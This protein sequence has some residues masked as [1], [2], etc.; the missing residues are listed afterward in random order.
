MQGKAPTLYDVTSHWFHGNSIPKIGGR[1]FWPRPIVFPKNTLPYDEGYLFCFI[2]ISSL[3]LCLF[4][5]WKPGWEFWLLLVLAYIFKQTF[6]SFWERV[7]MARTKPGT[8]TWLLRWWKDSWRPARRQTGS[9]NWKRKLP[10]CAGGL[11]TESL[12]RSWN[13]L[14]DSS[15]SASPAAMEKTTTAAVPPFQ[16]SLVTPWAAETA[17]A[18]G[19]PRRPKIC[20]RL[21][22][23]ELQEKKMRKLHEGL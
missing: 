1:Y 14:E 15:Y 11:E 6:W 8:W 4:V 3:F 9:R 10:R 22:S 23:L 7:S 2:L 13:G 18:W 12:W 19:S 21:F 17:Y 20:L 5:Q 16:G